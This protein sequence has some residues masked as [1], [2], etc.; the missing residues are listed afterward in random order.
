M[1]TSSSLVCSALAL[2]L[3]AAC[4]DDNDPAQDDNPIGVAGQGGD[5]SGGAAG[6]PL[7]GR[8]GAPS[9]A[10]GVGGSGSGG[11]AGTPVSG[12]PGK[13]W[14]ACAPVQPDTGDVTPAQASRLV[15]GSASPMGITSDDHLIYREGAK[16]MA[17]KLGAAP[18]TPSL[19]SDQSGTP[20]FKGSVVFVWSNIDYTAGQADLLAWTG[21]DC[22]RPIGRT[23]F[24]DEFVA[25]SADGSMLLMPANVTETTMDLEVTARDLSWRRILVTG[26]G[27]ASDTTCR[28]QY[29]FAGGRVVVGH[30]APGSL[31]ATLDAFTGSGDAWQKAEIAKDAQTTWSSDAAGDRIF[32]TTRGAQARLWGGQDM[33]EIDTGVVW[34]QVVPDGSG[35]FYTVGDQLRR[36]GLPEVLAIPIVTNKFQRALRWS[37]DYSQVLYATAVTYEGGERHDLVLTSTADFNP[38][39][40]KLVT[41]VDATLSRSAFSA[42]NK[43]VTYLTGA[44][45]GAGTLNVHSIALGQT[46]TAPAVGT[47]AAAHDG[48]FVFSDNQ[49]APDVYPAT[50]DLKIWDAAGPGLPQP[51]QSKIVDG[52]AFFVAPGGHAVVYQRLADAQQADAEG[53]WAS[54]LP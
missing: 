34:G 48:V 13:L 44:N 26:I 1:R 25:A 6:T 8:A 40:R 38:S 4:N 37:T 5:D 36:T 29:G 14:P 10:A 20:L 35:I 52:R 46:R 27:R 41:T 53:V 11:T 18:A 23:L 17:V 16:L 33:G 43:F 21:N 2:S 45:A 51:L 47:V 50:A 15:V 31:S 39:P 32:Y 54:P 7:G 28:A 12:E 19:V 30:C 42:D 49:S 22:A 24:S 9:G 3:L